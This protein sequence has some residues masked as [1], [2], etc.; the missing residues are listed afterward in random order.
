MKN[1]FNLI[2]AL[3]AISALI[4]GTSPAAA[5]TS[6]SGSGATFALPLI[7]A[8]KGEFTAATG[9]TVNY[10]GGG[11]G[12]GRTDFSANLVDFAGSD[13]PY[14][15]GAPENLIYAPI[16]A[17]PISVFYNLPTIEE[18]IYLTPATVANIFKGFITN[19]NDPKIAKDNE[20]SVTTVVYR[21]KKITT[22]VKG[23]KVTKTVPVLDKKGK[24][25][26]KSTKST[27]VNINLPDQQITVWYRTDGSGTSENFGNFLNG[28]AS[29]EWPNKGGS[30]FSSTTPSPI[31]SYF[32]FQGASGSSAVAV[33][34]KGKIGSIGYGELSFA[35]DNKLL[36]ANIQNAAGEFIAPTAAGTSAF[37]GGG[38]INA[39]GTLS[40]EYLKKI[41]GAYP[42]GTASYG[43]AYPAAA[44]KNAN[45]QVD[46]AA[47]FTYILDQCPVKFPEKGF[48]KITG[49][50]YDKAKQQ[51]ALIK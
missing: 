32:N 13:A 20:R 44:N 45:K 21:T 26:V 28:A 35:N 25:I 43:L 36:S 31:T 23:Q 46:V 39:N 27:K 6:I 51:I 10:P 24:P 49:P 14:T 5:N 22:T 15:S 2:V 8:C 42:I 40:Y 7:D 3:L 17:A 47:W 38:T 48:S 18:S 29:N 19:W 41:S 16:Y 33:G 4:A 50:L 1:R 30:T 11:S 9:N 12:K 37:L 34:V